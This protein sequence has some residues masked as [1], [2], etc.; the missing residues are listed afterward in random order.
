MAVRFLAR[1]VSDLCLGKPALRALPISATVADALS[2]LKRSGESYISVWSCEHSRSDFGGGSGGCG[3]VGKVCLVD[4]ICFL[5]GEKNLLNPLLA[6]QAPVSDLLP[7]VPGLVRHLEPH[8]SLLEAID[9]I[10]EGTQNL[11]VPI[12]SNLS[13]T[14]RKKLLNKTSSFVSS[15]LHN[16][17]EYCWLT[18]EDVVRFLLNSIGVFSPLPAFTIESLNIID[19]NIMTIYYDN[20]ASSALDSI[21][22]FL[23]EQKS[24]GVVD[25]YN[26]LIGEIS[27]YTLA[28]CN[29]AVVGAIT[30]LSAGDLMAYID[31][32]GP[33]EDLVQLVKARLEEKNLGA[34]LEFIEELS[35]SSASS[36]SSCSSD[37]E[38]GLGKSSGAG[39][40]S[41]ARRSEVIVC[42]PWS[43]LVAVMIQ[44]LAHRVNYA[45][46]VD[47][48]YSVVGIVTF[49]GI[50]KVFR[51]IAGSR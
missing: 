26:K 33:P 36:Q 6:L 1:E 38:F 24:I 32:G 28:C 35:F 20:P 34:I 19:T 41:A 13:I 40:Y 42:W 4:V 18:Q 14:S 15:T 27:P 8:S 49:A 10:L 22:R 44:A 11:V 16:G 7:K 31:Y 17:H 37:E 51:S 9:Y 5:C 23:T 29:E 50:L 30:T 39:R 12:E 43:S 2:A 48:D 25:E 46:V 21:S 3:C 45:W 47:E